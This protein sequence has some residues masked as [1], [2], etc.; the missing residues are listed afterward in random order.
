MRVRFVSVT[1]TCTYNAVRHSVVLGIVKRW[2]CRGW[3]DRTEGM[4]DESKKR[5]EKKREEE[6]RVEKRRVEEIVEKLI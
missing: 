3:Q 1:H 6:S 4:M 5:R 2:Q